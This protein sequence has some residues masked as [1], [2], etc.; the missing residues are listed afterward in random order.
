[1]GFTIQFESHRVELAAIYEMEHDRD[2]LEYYDQPPSFKLNYCSSSGRHLGV[3]HTADYFVIRKESAG[4]EECK[5]HDDLV[6]LSER[7]GNRYCSEDGTTWHC[8]PGESH[9]S[10]MGLY[11]RVR[12]SSDIDWVFQRNIQ[13]LE[14]Y[15]R[16]DRVLPSNIRET[17]IAH[18]NA[19]PDLRLEQ[20]LRSVAP[21]ATCDDVYALI[22]TGGIYVDLHD[23]SLTEPAKVRVFLN[24]QMLPAIPSSQ[25][26]T[27]QVCGAAP[28]LRSKTEELLATANEKDLNI[29]NRRLSQITAFLQDREPGDDTLPPLRTRQRWAAAYRGA[30]L[31]LGS[32]YLGLIPQPR[33][34]NCN[35]KLPD[36]SRTLMAEFISS[37]YESLKQKTRYASWMALSLASEEKGIICPSYKTFCLAVRHRPGFEQTMKRQGPRAAYQQEPFFWQLEFRTPP[38]GDRPFEIAH[39]DHTELDVESVCSRTG[40]GLG[41]TWLTLLTDAFSRRILALYLTFDSP[42]YRSCMMVLRECV[43]RHSRL[44]QI[45]VVDG[46]REFQSTYFE[47]LLARFELVKKTRPPAKPRFG[48]VCERLFGT[49]NTQF[50]HNLQ[51]NTQL[52]VKVRQVTQSV[53][54]KGQAIWSFEALSQRITEYA[55]EVYD[56]CS[57]PALG[58]SPRETYQAGF[59]RTGMRTHRQIP[60]DREF[61]I[62]TLPTTPKGTAKVIPGKGIQINY[63]YYWSDLFR[64]PEVEK[65]NIP[66]RYDPF[67]AGTAHGFVNGQWTECHSEHYM[68]FR[69]RTEKEIMLASQELR[70]IRQCHSQQ[71]KVTATKLAE[72]LESVESEEALL[73]QRLSDAE[74]RQP[75]TTNSIS[76]A[77]IPLPPPA[78][79]AGVPQIHTGRTPRVYGAF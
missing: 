32:G 1:M 79:R 52:T 64:N 67:D 70:R 76:S 19:E 44:P 15:F 73:K 16:D 13:F 49:A 26:I 69:D 51:G 25:Q 11:Y 38:H 75:R 42:S 7:N 77:L 18:V 71:F 33:R 36:E 60:Y 50:L 78:P 24:E 22:A 65:Q 12:S 68:I 62:L 23:T 2:V 55:Y 46:G 37:D 30:E 54:P 27:L 21:A 9:A 57:H 47:T 39:I 31:N 6:R 40:R 59:L 61:L 14:D 5:T 66:E 63:L 72:F 58:A 53:N 10:S 17:V 74:S 35:P 29:A 48:S 3:I 8:P 45:I 34:G 56:T 28:G 43:R 41:R 4:W 20:L